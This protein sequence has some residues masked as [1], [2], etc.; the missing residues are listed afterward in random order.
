MTFAWFGSSVCQLWLK[1][2]ALSSCG[3]EAEMKEEPKN[4]P[5]DLELCL[6]LAFSQKVSRINDET[7]ILRDADVFDGCRWPEMPYLRI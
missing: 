2:S 6:N 4:Q 5:H 7:S 1:D 3:S